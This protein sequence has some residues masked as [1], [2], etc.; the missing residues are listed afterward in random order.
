MRQNI[1]FVKAQKRAVARYR[2]AALS[3]VDNILAERLPLWF[4]DNDVSA[5]STQFWEH[6]IPMY[7]SPADM[8]RALAAPM[9]VHRAGRAR[10]GKLQDGPKK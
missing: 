7:L 8:R 1:S 2:K 5:L 6:F 4:D 3:F 9:H 10:A